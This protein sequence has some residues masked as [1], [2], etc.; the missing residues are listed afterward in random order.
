[1]IELNTTYTHS[2]NALSRAFLVAGLP[3]GKKCL[4]FDNQ[5]D[6]RIFAKTLAFVTGQEATLISDTASLLHFLS[7][8]DGYFLTTREIF[9]LRA[10]IDYLEKKYTL[11]LSRKSELS[12]EDLIKTL[13]DFGYTH[14]PHL[15]K[16]GS[17]KKDGDTISIRSAFA[18]DVYSL[19]FFDT[20]LDEILLFDTV[21][22]YR[23]KHD[24]YTLVSLTDNTPFESLQEGKT[25]EIPV[26][27]PYLADTVTVCI[28]LDFFDGLDQVA[29]HCPNCIVFSGNPLGKHT[30][31]GIR[32][33]KIET[34]S[35][36][37]TIVREHGKT[38]HFYTKH[39]KALRNFLEYNALTSG[40]IRETT[41]TGLESFVSKQSEYHIT[42]DVL[43]RIFIRNRTKK[44]I[45]KNLDL[46]L[47]IRPNDYI[48]HRDH[49]VGI[50]REIVEKDLGGNK[51]EY[52]AIEYAANDRLFVPLA[53]IH[54]V[55]KYIGDEHPKLTRLSTTEWK[56]VLEKTTEDVERIAQE[57]LDI[58]AHRS[59][60]RGFSFRAHPREER[61][62]RDDFK[63]RHTP[64]QTTAILE[65][66]ADMESD[67]PMERLLSGDVGFGKT[68][69]AMNAIYKATLSGKQSAF[70]SPLVV[71]AYEH[72]ESLQ[73]R[74]RESGVRLAV[75]TRLTSTKEVRTILQGLRDGTIDCVVGT[76]RLLGEDIVF[77]NLGLLVIDEEHRF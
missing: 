56:K 2:G 41:M 10:N 57:L 69:V 58:Y 23:A 31:L 40:S 24:A 52:M 15:S 77:K 26:L 46:L 39:A 64:D 42:D 48:V 17:Y 76:H 7:S 13:I 73:E 47:E 63:Y 49:G 5:A 18:S 12:I 72:Y 27:C 20:A 19:S 60:A 34:L 75:M 6:L 37:E 30:D 44:S 16:P 54:R 8:Q 9:T 29:R 28:D 66:F 61:A 36:L 65:I 21:G 38:V 11:P 50:F 43:S 68:E 70:I 33:P 25:P 35:D 22:N 1:M 71:L 14:S 59:L 67:E 62:F 74:F 32:E 4:V 53:E 55:S 51:R 3:A 45:A